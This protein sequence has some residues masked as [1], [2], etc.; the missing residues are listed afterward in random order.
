MLPGASAQLGTARHFRSGLGPLGLLRVAGGLVQLTGWATQGAAC[1][2]V[3]PLGVESVDLGEASI[4]QEPTKYEQV[5]TYGPRPS[6][7]RTY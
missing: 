1:E 5:V 4:D 2:E 6:G 7:L 3:Q